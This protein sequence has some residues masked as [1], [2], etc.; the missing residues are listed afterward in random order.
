MKNKTLIIYFAEDKKCRQIVKLP[1]TF[2]GSPKDLAHDI[3]HGTYHSFD[4]V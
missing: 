2:D 3:S 1:N 4:I